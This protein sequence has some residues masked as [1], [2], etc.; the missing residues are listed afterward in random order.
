MDGQEI[1]SLPRACHDRVAL[2]SVKAIVGVAGGFAVLGV[3][4]Q[5]LVLAHYDF[6]K[7]HCTCRALNGLN[8]VWQVD[9]AYFRDLNSV[10]IRSGKSIFTF[11]LG[12]GEL[13]APVIDASASIPAEQSRSLRAGYRLLQD[14]PP[15]LML[16]LA[17]ETPSVMYSQ[18]LYR[19]PATGQLSL[20][21]HKGRKCQFTPVED[22]A[23]IYRHYHISLARLAGERLAVYSNGHYL[24]VYSLPDGG[25]VGRFEVESAAGF[26]FSQDGTHLATMFETDRWKV[27]E[28]VPKAPPRLMTLPPAPNTMPGVDLGECWM[29]LRYAGRCVLIRWEK[30]QL[31]ETWRE[32]KR[33]A[34]VTDELRGTTLSP[35]R[36]RARGS[37]P[38]AIASTD[39]ARYLRSCTSTLIAV[40]D[41]FGQVMLFDRRYQL[42]AMFYALNGQLAGWMPDGTCF[43]PPSLLGRSETPGARRHMGQALLEA[44][45]LNEET[46]TWMP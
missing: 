22:G 33:G 40:L 34:F 7:R 11:D 20:L 23:Y 44:W 45:R 32:G 4:G 17:S 15:S 2:R 10:A 41:A 3:A 30:G 1:E 12:K 24:R 38:S 9:G 26:T 21:D 25:L 5:K 46:Q 28:T 37:V 42:L 6:E 35:H 31:E 36:V 39:Y 8:Q 14:G 13:T 29:L 19:D 18:T 27:Q 16:R 43:G